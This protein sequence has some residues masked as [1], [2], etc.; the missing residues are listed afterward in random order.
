M[1]SSLIITEEMHGKWIWNSNVLKKK[2]KLSKL[3]SCRGKGTCDAWSMV[4]EDPLVM[5]DG[6][7]SV[8]IMEKG[9]PGDRK[10][11]LRRRRIS[12]WR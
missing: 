6:L 2:F 8:D 5:D 12:Q 3:R 9:Q 1:N 4:E 7:E 11:L 10:K